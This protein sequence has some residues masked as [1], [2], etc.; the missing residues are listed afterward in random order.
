MLSDRLSNHS[1]MAHEDLYC[2]H[3]RCL[4]IRSPCNI[5]SQHELPSSAM[6]EM[7][8]TSSSTIAMVELRFTEK[9]VLLEDR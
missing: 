8:I 3:P 4:S 2:H 5:G 6:L 1:C 9:T 7:H